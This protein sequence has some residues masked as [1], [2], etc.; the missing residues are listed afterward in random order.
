[1]DINHILIHPYGHKLLSL[2]DRMQEVK[3]ANDVHRHSSYKI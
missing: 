3:A 1:M 2:V